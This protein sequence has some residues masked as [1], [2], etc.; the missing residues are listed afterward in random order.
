MVG[1][2]LL[3]VLVEKG[4]QILFGKAFRRCMFGRVIVE[5]EEA[6]T[7]VQSRGSRSTIIVVS[8]IAPII[9]AAVVPLAR[10]AAS[11]RS[12]GHEFRAAV[13]GA[14]VEKQRPRYRC[15]SARHEDDKFLLHWRLSKRASIRHYILRVE[16]MLGTGQAWPVRS[17]SQ[18]RLPSVSG[19]RPKICAVTPATHGQQDHDGVNPPHG[20]SSDVGSVLVTGPYTGYHA[21]KVPVS[22]TEAVAPGATSPTAPP[23]YSRW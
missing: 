18:G 23:P 1:G 9:I 13:M 11:L 8:A 15:S 17:K 7:V 6:G 14:C 5:D 12:P 20:G 16:A 4:K 22:T 21:G 10:P 19:V 2:E 3:E